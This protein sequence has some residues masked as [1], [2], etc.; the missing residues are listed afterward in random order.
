MKKKSTR[1]KTVIKVAQSKED[2]AAEILRDSQQ[3]LQTQQQRLVELDN[4]FAEYSQNFVNNGNQQGFKAGLMVSYQSFLNKIKQAIEQQKKMVDIARHQVEE[5]RLL[6]L[7]SRNDKKLVDGVMDKYLLQEQQWLD[8][9]E[10]KETDERGQ[11]LVNH[12]LSQK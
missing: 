3:N 2:K 7:K 6:W 1:F 8:K 10:Q 12:F 5:K 11:R 9:Q 4:F